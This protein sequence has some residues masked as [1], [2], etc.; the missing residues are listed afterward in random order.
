M[1]GTE[2]NDQYSYAIIGAAMQVHAELGCGFLEAVYQDA[3]EIEFQ[4]RNIPFVREER[5]PIYYSGQKLKTY[6][7]ADF[8]CNDTTIVELKALTCIS[9]VEISQVLNYLKATRKPKALLLNF[10]E[11]SLRVKRFVGQTAMPNQ[12]FANTQFSLLT[13]QNPYNNT[14]C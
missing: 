3:L 4:N 2:N 10:G 6:Y 14:L 13:S 12:S 9:N 11:R 5:I 8:V 7:I 1:N